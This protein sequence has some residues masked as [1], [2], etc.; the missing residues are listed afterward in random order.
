[1]VPDNTK[2]KS[3]MYMFSSMKITEVVNSDRVHF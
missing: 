2:A 1:M 3:N